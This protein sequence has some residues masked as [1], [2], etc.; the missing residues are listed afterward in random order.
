MLVAGAALNY[1]Y[2]SHPIALTLSGFEESITYIPNEAFE[3]QNSFWLIA[4]LVFPNPA[5]PRN[6]TKSP[7]ALTTVPWTV[8]DQLAMSAVP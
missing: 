1:K 4:F 6:L 3:V 8:S 5:V 2:L 7:R